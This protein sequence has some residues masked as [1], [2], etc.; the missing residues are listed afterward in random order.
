MRTP[1]PTIVIVDNPYQENKNLKFEGKNITTKSLNWDFLFEI[2]KNNGD[3]A[4]EFKG[5]NCT[6]KLTNYICDTYYKFIDFLTFG[7]DVYGTIRISLDKKTNAL[8]VN[9][10][11]VQD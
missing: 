2:A 5:P 11:Q 1:I 6:G 7:Y 9:Y 8:K 4:V 10:I 3:L